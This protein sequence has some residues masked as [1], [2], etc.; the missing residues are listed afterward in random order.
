MIELALILAAGILAVLIPVYACA[1][2]LEWRAWDNERRIQRLRDR[3][4]GTVR[5]ST[6]TST[7][8]WNS[9]DGVT[10]DAGRQA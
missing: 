6:L 8:E 3:R 5:N 1:R 9:R 2:Y 7:F 4:R 10:F